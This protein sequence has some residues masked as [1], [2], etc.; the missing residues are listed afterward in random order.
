LQPI[1]GD[2]FFGRESAQALTASRLCPEFPGRLSC[3]RACAV[4]HRAG[5]RRSS[6][7]NT[8]VEITATGKARGFAMRSTSTETFALPH[9]IPRAGPM[10]QPS[11]PPENPA[12]RLSA[13]QR[14]AKRRGVRW[15]SLVCGVRPALDWRASWK[16]GHFLTVPSLQKRFLGRDHFGLV[17]LLTAHQYPRR[18]GLKFKNT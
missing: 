15:R 7:P 6:K 18:N 2:D 10:P 14:V 5:P 12:L 8:P 16:S 3:D 9:S 17:T 1:R 13:R 11:A 4:R